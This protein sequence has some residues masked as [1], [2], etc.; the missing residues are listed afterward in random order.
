[1]GPAS[2][3]PH[4]ELAGQGRMGKAEFPFGP[5]LLEAWE[6]NSAPDFESLRLAAG[7][8]SSHIPHLPVIQEAWLLRR[9]KKIAERARKGKR[10]IQ[11][12]LLCINRLKVWKSVKI[13]FT[14]G[15]TRGS[16]SSQMELCP[17]SWALGDISTA[18]QE[19]L[20]PR[21]AVVMVCGDV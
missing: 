2:Y 3:L 6:L 21:Q 5:V 11:D 9:K 19:A 12:E 8:Q 18:S 7:A 4:F 17:F 16:T 14:A 13:K 15:G 1:M 20:V 10:W